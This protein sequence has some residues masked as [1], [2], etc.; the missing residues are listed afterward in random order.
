M[1]GLSWSL[2]LRAR[3]WCAALLAAGLLTL[4]AGVAVAQ[5]SSDVQFMGKALFE[6]GIRSWAVDVQGHYAYVSAFDYGMVVLD[7][8][9]PAHPV[10]VGRFMDARTND[11]SVDGNLAIVLEAYYGIDFVDVSDP[12]NPVKTTGWS[13]ILTGE[14]KAALVSGQHVY[15][16]FQGHD[17]ETDEEV[18]ELRVIDVSNP[19]DPH[20]VGRLTLPEPGGKMA[21]SGDYLYMT[22]GT[23]L[24][25]VNV[26]DPTYP[27]LVG[28]VAGP[29]NA[30]DIVAQGNYLFV[31][32][33]D[34]VQVFSAADPVA[35]ALVTSWTGGGGPMD[36]AADYLYVG[37]GDLRVVDVCD[38][39][40]PLE[41]GYYIIS[42]PAVGDV[43]AYGKYPVI[44]AD[45]SGTLVLKF[46]GGEGTCPGAPYLYTI[47]D[48][49][50]D[51][52]YMVH[53]NPPS[54]P[55][56]CTAYT[57][58]E[59][60]NL[61]FLHPTTVYQDV[62]RMVQLGGR[63]PGKY[64]YRVR[65][66]DGFCDGPWSN[67]RSVTVCPAVK[68]PTPTR[69]RTPWPTASPSAS[70]TVTEVP[71]TATEVLPTPTTTSTGEATPTETSTPTSSPSA[72]ITPTP[73]QTATPGALTSVTLQDGSEG[74]AGQEDAYIS[75]SFSAE[76]YCRSDL[77]QVGMGQRYAALLRFDLSSIPASSIVSMA[78]LVV[79]ARG[80]SG[81]NL[82]IEAYRILRGVN[83]CEV[84]WAQAHSGENW[85]VPGCNHTVTDRAATAEDRVTTAGVSRWYSWHLGALVQDWVDGDLANNGVLLRSTSA[86]TNYSLYFAGDQALTQS[87][88]PVL[89]LY[90]RPGGGVGPTRS[91]TPTTAVSP[92]A[93]RV[94][95]G[96]TVTLQTG[97]DGYSGEEDTYIHAYA[98]TANYCSATTLRVGTKQQYAGLLRFDLAGLP[99]HSAIVSARLRLYAT[100][101]GGANMTLSAY[102]VLRGMQPCQATWNRASAAE[103]WG[104][105]GCN[106]AYTDRS[107]GPESSVST[108]GI[109]K[110]CEWDLTALVRAW[111]GGLANNGVLLRGASATS[112]A[113]FYFASAQAGTLGQR[114]MLVVV[115][116]P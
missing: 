18:L 61:S 28:L 57:L 95:P 36:I 70:P 37:G 17:L 56:P 41:V 32:N 39:A 7:L 101:W 1:R 5:D 96:I 115:Y 99:A 49:N 2:S 59:D 46:T 84:T 104:L 24:R 35:P 63:G 6:S 68:T 52:A 22:T 47:D 31:S 106:Y 72:T 45:Y 10:Q 53:W 80:W 91:P 16:S 40:H 103:A 79:Y 20:T 23:G 64:Y 30:W 62:Q 71:P 67:T 81:G 109:G 111:D 100:G 116:Q 60:D 69:T 29:T 34:V 105:P 82:T 44:T 98:P 51:G 58:Q 19:Y 75:Q 3:L 26:S 14:Y 38:P 97:T 50:C 89:R 86:G 55:I 21:R 9:D 94:V 8:S 74:Y 90:Y 25:V 76:N 114:P 110:W 85:G 78:E 83:M 112:T 65:A 4:W 92:T 66:S 108:N 48:S 87:Q 27:R 102:R 88:R 54:N 77:L 73:T 43:A 11:L 107:D 15:A 12:T 113:E 93:T 13:T 33:E 42:D